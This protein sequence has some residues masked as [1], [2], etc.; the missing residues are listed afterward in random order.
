VRELRDLPDELDAG[1]PRSDDDEGQ[2]VR[3]LLR[4]GGD[5]GHLELGEDRVARVPGVLDGLHPGREPGVF[6]VP[7]VG[8]ADACGQDEVVVAEFDLLA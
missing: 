6:V 5:L 2:P 1:R 7:E 8:L 4:V 3:A